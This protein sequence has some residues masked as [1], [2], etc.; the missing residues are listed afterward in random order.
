MQQI[1]DWTGMCGRLVEFL[2]LGGKVAVFGGIF[3]G[4]GLAVVTLI[5][6]LRRP[7]TGAEE[8]PLAAPSPTAVLDAVKAFLQGLSSAPTWIAM[9]GIGIL[10]LWVAGNQIN[11]CRRPLTPPAA[12]SPAPSQPAPSATR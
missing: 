1:P 7:Q 9:L 10:M 6:A 5:L 3:L 11:E 4:I 2:I 8:A 12:Q